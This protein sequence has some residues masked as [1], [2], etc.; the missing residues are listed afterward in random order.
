MQ[1]VYD[2]D[3]LKRLLDNLYLITGRKF[4][5]KSSE[6]DDVMTG[7]AQSAFCTLIQDTADGYK[8][9][10]DCNRIA[11]EHTRI[12]NQPYMFRCHCGLIETAIPIMDGKTLLAYLM[13]GQVLDDSPIDAQWA[14]TKRLCAWHRNLTGL[15]EAFFQLQCLHQEELA[16]YTDVLAACASYIWLQDYVHQ[17]ELTDAEKLR[18]YIDLHYAERLSLRGIAHALGMSKTRLCETARN[19]GITVN[20]EITARRMETAKKLL[21]ATDRPVYTIADAVGIS[22]YSYFSRRFKAH[23]GETPNQYRRRVISDSQKEI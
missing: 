5:L 9:C 8:K 6:F 15:K 12:S 2:F 22:D 7:H 11:L 21:A 1:S 14:I 18:G 19:A 16:A 23:T 17:S 4:T 3:K 20:A 13:Y 10:L